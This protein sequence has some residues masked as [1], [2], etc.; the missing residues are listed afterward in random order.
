MNFTLPEI[1][2]LD[3]IKVFTEDWYMEA[4][5]NTSQ[6]EENHG[7]LNTQNLIHLIPK[8]NPNTKK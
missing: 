3:L 1:S 5:L 4:S 6:K 7:L 2:N 8:I